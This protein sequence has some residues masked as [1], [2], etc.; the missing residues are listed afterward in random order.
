M[1]SFYEARS[2]PQYI[3]GAQDAR[4]SYY[5]REDGKS[6][7]NAAGVQRIPCTT[8]KYTGK[9]LL[10]SPTGRKCGHLPVPAQGS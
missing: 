4:V 8:L 6:L 10:Q 3:T 5:G 9:V 1:T 7:C 2:R